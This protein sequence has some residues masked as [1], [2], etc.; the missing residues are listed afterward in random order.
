MGEGGIKRLNNAELYDSSTRTW[1]MI[2]GMNIARNMHTASVLTNGKMLVVGGLGGNDPLKSIRLNS[3]ELY[4]PSTG[5]WT[6]TGQM[7]H[8]RQ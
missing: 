1:T 4:D 6:I 5:L 8:A 3:T 2:N 7:K